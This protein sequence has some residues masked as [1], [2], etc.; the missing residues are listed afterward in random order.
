MFSARFPSPSAFSAAKGAS[1]ASVSATIP[2]A[3]RRSRPCGL[4]ARGRDC[5]GHSL[6][7]G[8]RSEGVTLRLQARGRR[9]TSRSGARGP[10]CD[11]VLGT[12]A[13]L[14]ACVAVPVAGAGCWGHMG[15]TG[16]G[17]APGLCGA[18]LAAGSG[19]ALTEPLRPQSLGVR[20][21]V[22]Y[23]TAAPRVP[24]TRPAAPAPGRL[25]FAVRLHSPWPA[26]QLPSNQ[27]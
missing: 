19:L 9:V 11:L 3:R 17:A 27:L 15:A 2:C 18:S 22:P 16:G 20:V 4:R 26:G 24:G 6:S 1:Q 7:A 10:F 12:V 21:Q 25:H 23:A 8:P 14:P 13:P 5:A